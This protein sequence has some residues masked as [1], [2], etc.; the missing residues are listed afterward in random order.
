MTSNNTDRIARTVKKVRK[1]LDSI[2][3]D[4][5]TALGPTDVGIIVNRLLEVD[6]MRTVGDLLVHNGIE[7][8][9]ESRDKL[10]HGVEDHAL[11]Y[12]GGLDNGFEKAVEIVTVASVTK[13]RSEWSDSDLEALRAEM[14][15]FDRLGETRRYE[16]P[17]TYLNVNRTAADGKTDD[18]DKE[19]KSEEKEIQTGD[20][21]QN[22]S[23]I[24]RRKPLGEY[25]ERCQDLREEILNN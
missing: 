14:R 5:H 25:E 24:N 22:V 11:F 1:L 6:K 18:N 2:A 17:D 4:N 9:N 13:P 21:S 8:Q 23:I 20:N 10:R 7:N 16:N 19:V 12:V 15:H 3:E